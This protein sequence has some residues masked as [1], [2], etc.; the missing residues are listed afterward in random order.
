MQENK[1]MAIKFI[2][3]IVFAILLLM[4]IGSVIIKYDN[5]MKSRFIL[6]IVFCFVEAI[7][8]AILLKQSKFAASR[9]TILDALSIVFFILL[10]ADFGKGL[11]ET[12]K[13]QNA[14]NGNNGYLYAYESGIGGKGYD[15]LESILEHEIEFKKKNINLAE[16]EEIYRIQVGD[17]FFVYFKIA[18]GIME[19]E[20]FRQNDLFYSSGNKKLMYDGMVSY[21]GYTVDET[22]RKDI[23]NTMWRGVT[24]KAASPAWG[25]SDDERIFSMTVNSKQ[26][27]DTILIDE[28]D[29][30]KY[31]FWLITDVDE[32]K[33]IDDVKAAEIEMNEL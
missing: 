11:A 1:G 5:N 31:Y 26:I 2:R 29:G 4:F 21:E 32:I 28:I 8:I 25:V 7:L 6:F 19:L 22:I 17:R 27:D 3:I 12:N 30:K 23:A 33:T 15:D 13:I 20:F 24:G 14:F 9:I 18:E 16:M 10:V